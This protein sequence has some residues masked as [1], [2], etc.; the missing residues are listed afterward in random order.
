M[1]HFPGVYSD[2]SSSRGGGV[3]TEESPVFVSASG[4]GQ[5]GFEG[6]DEEYERSPAHATDGSRALFRTDVSQETP[7]PRLQTYQKPY[8]HQQQVFSQQQPNCLFAEGKMVQST[9]DGRF[10]PNFYFTKP[11]APHS[12]G[13]DL[14]DLQGQAGGGFS[15]DDY[16]LFQSVS[17]RCL[18]H[19]Y[20][21]YLDS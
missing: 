6:L 21:V 1:D 14:L 12:T 13:L 11:S 17:E 3:Q 9:E 10:E 20:S 19:L 8:S 2:S 16:F 18:S 5:S 7:D 15:P 4:N